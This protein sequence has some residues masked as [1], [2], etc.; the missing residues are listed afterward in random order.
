MAVLI[1]CGIF[2][3]VAG[4]SRLD[5]PLANPVS[6]S[7]LME[8]LEADHPA[9]KNT[10]ITSGERKAIRSEV[11]VLVNGVSLKDTEL[12][13]GPDDEVVIMLRIAGG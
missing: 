1:F 6:F 13:V 8:K 10:V 4:E 11:I 9:M 2:E 5:W 7:H 3:D 12:L